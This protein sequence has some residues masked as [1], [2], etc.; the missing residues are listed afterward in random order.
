MKKACLLL[1]SNSRLPINLLVEQ[2]VLIKNLQQENT[3]RNLQYSRILLGV[4]LISILPYLTTLFTS[5][6]ALLSLLSITSLLS[7]AYLL[8]SLPPG[9]TG[10]SVLDSLNTPSKLSSR[11]Q[12]QHVSHDGPIKQYLPLLNMGLSGIL[13]LLGMVVSRR[14]SGL[15]WGFGWLPAG[16][17]AV[18][19]LAKWVMGS[20]D[21]EGELGE[22][23]YGF[24]G[25]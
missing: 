17:Y 16:V 7:T 24:K 15:W 6:T 11:G 22:L 14:D 21:P 12:V 8:T 23:K 25:A 13:V 18:V 19:I 9:I 20:V 2:E 10:I 3:T 1:L 5:Q 4:P